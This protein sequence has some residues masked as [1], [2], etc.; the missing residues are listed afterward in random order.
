MLFIDVATEKVDFQKNN[1]PHALA[2]STFPHCGAEKQSNEFE[3][4]LPSTVFYTL[5]KENLGFSSIFF[6]QIQPQNF[7][8]FRLRQIKKSTSTS[9]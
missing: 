5:Q 8:F 4:S 7:S 9:A 1:T 6:I 2:K 3:M